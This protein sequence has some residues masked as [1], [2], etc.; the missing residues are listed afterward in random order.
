VKRKDRWVVFVWDNSGGSAEGAIFGPFTEYSKAEECWKGWM[1]EMEGEL[2]GDISPKI[3]KLTPPTKKARLAHLWK[4]K[5]TFL[6]GDNSS[7]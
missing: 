5:N 1:K 7:D 3:I 4:L 2:G 6:D